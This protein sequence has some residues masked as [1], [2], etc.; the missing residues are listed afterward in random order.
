[1]L[2]KDILQADVNT[3]GSGSSV[4][5][6]KDLWPLKEFSEQFP[7]ASSYTTNEYFS[8]YIPNIWQIV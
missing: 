1:M 7:R 6:W 5:F 2:W 3:I 8:S 4:L